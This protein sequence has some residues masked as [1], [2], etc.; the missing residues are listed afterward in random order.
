MNGSYKSI[1]NNDKTLKGRQLDGG[2]LYDNNV[3]RQEVA[4]NTTGS[5][6]SRS[7][8]IKSGNNRKPSGFK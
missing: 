8:I 4:K 1:T 5:D 2:G 6:H 3:Y 7:L